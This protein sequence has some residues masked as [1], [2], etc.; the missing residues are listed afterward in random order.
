MSQESLIE[1]KK[2]NWLSTPSAHSTHIAI[3]YRDRQRC[4]LVFP[5]KKTWEKG[6]R[7]NMLFHRMRARLCVSWVRRKKSSAWCCL[8]QKITF[9]SRIQ[10]QF[11][12]SQKQLFYI[13]FAFVVGLRLIF[14]S[15]PK[16]ENRQEKNWEASKQ[17]NMYRRC[18]WSL[19]IDSN[20]T[21]AWGDE[22][23]LQ[24]SFPFSLSS[25]HPLLLLKQRTSGVQNIDD[26]RK[27]IHVMCDNFQLHISS[28]SHRNEIYVPIQSN[29]F[30]FSVSPNRF[31][32]SISFNIVSFYHVSDFKSRPPPTYPTDDVLSSSSKIEFRTNWVDFEW[33]NI[34]LVIEQ[35]EKS[36]KKA[37]GTNENELKNF[38]PC[39]TATFWADGV[40]CD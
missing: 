11:D 23:A 1:L 39:S 31:S 33:K 5:H 27:H 37:P 12:V 29:K 16:P 4:R 14:H 28:I 25:M 40:L 30:S 20:S 32:V 7:K 3:S 34:W 10:N 38:G 18:V 2:R 8:R 19:S 26:E 15:F 24:A 13:I 6:E 17:R 21:R 9:P 35:Q 36:F 22:R